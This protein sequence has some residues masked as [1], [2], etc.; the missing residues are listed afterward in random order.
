MKPEQTARRDI[1]LFKEMANALFSDYRRC[2]DRWEQSQVNRAEG[3]NLLEIMGVDTKEL[4]HSRLLEW[5]FARE[6]GQGT[7]AQGRLGFRLFLGS[8]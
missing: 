3:F 2:H 5:L 7:H 8:V 6:L 1:A 4:C